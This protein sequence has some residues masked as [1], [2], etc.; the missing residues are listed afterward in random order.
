ML[1]LFYPWREKAP[2]IHWIG[3]WVVP[4]AAG[5]FGEEE[6]LLL[7]MGVC[8]PPLSSAFS[9]CCPNYSCSRFLNNVLN[10]IES[11]VDLIT[12]IDANNCVVKIFCTNL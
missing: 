6:N 4:T 7:K 10:N 5:S 11:K 2:I 9:L 3:V 12:S 1:W 8:F